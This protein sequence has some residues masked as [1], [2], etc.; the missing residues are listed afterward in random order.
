M[1]DFWRA[2]ACLAACGAGWLFLQRIA[3]RFPGHGVQGKGAPS[4]AGDVA[5]AVVGVQLGCLFL[6]LTGRP[7]MAGALALGPAALLLALNRVKE[8]VLHEPLVLADAWLLPQVWKFPEMYVPYLPVKGILFGGGVFL[9][10]FCWLLVIEPVMAFFA[11]NGSRRIIFF[12][13][14]LFPAALL[15]AARLGMAPPAVCR[16]LLRVLPVSH[17]A[18]ADAARNGTLAS[19]LMHPVL[20]GRLERD[21]PEFLRAPYVRPELSAWPDPLARLMREVAAAS[22]EKRPHALLVQAESFCDVREFLHGAQREALKNFLPNWDALEKQ[23]RTLPTPK[24]AYGAYT[25]RTEFSML[26]GLPPEVL[27][28]FAFNP[29]IPASRR[30]FWSLARFFR[31]HGYDALCAH[32]YYKSFFQRDKVM[33]NLGFQRFLGFEELRGIDRFGPYVGDAALGEKILEELSV[34]ENPLFCFIITMEAHG[35]W[36]EG[37]LTQKEI[38]ACLPDVDRALFSVEMQLYLCHL[39]H[40]DELFGTLRG[41]P[42][43]MLVYGDHLPGCASSLPTPACA[44]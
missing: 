26:T 42:C 40:M 30:P 8:R 27:G 6:S 12:A 17:D 13:A 36:L 37:R 24:D 5:A 9:L 21:E 14:A 41:A 10:C 33:A 43:E 25:M 38:A 35:P 4:P 1:A 34:A 7:F 19:A 22:P 2:T 11:D 16:F 32:P 15:L 39:R 29:Y 23:G 44:Y 31:D 3:M 28:P 18:A 20:A